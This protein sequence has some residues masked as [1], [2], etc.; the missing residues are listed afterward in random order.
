MVAE[1]AVKAAVQNRAAY[2][3]KNSETLTLKSARR[4][5]EE[6]LGLADKELD[7]LKAF[8]QDLVDKVLSSVEDASS[9]KA[10]ASP[11]A[12]PAAAATK[13]AESKSKVASAKQVDGTKKQKQR[14]SN[15]E[16]KENKQSNA[17]GDKQLAMQIMPVSNAVLTVRGD[18]ARDASTSGDGD[19]GGSTISSEGEGDQQTKKRRKRAE[20]PTKERTMKKEK[21]DKSKKPAQAPPRSARVEELKSLIKRCGLTVSPAVWKQVKGALERDVV[22]ALEAVLAKEG[23]SPHPTESEIRAVKGRKELNRELDG[24]D[25]SNIVSRSRRAAAPRSFA[26]TEPPLQ[27][28]SDE[29]VSALPRLWGPQCRRRLKGKRH[30]DVGVQGDSLSESSSDR[31][32]DDAVV[33][34]DDDEGAAESEEQQEQDE[35]EYEE[36]V[37]PARKKGRQAVIDD[38]E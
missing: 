28:A 17:D 6:D 13:K 3:R 11:N 24:I 10:A 16:D 25:T 33:D 22:K 15:K 34:D 5:L 35:Q 27:L 9:Q 21:P 2:F 37:P 23:L 1:D 30:N 18:D 12:K 8:V 38:D 19:A 7:S 4:L 29:E 14:K 32:N 31:S 26:A 36:D 20:G